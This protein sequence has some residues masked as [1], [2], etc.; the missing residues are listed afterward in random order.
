MEAIFIGT[1]LH[2]FS[3]KLQLEP[4]MHKIHQVAHFLKQLSTMKG[5]SQ[6]NAI[7]PTKAL[8]CRILIALAHSYRRNNSE[9]KSLTRKDDTS[10][11]YNQIR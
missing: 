9:T 7:E 2:L 8:T 6:L 3:Y 11:R 10:S 5:V 4:I 1:T